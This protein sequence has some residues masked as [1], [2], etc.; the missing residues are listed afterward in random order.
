MFIIKYIT[1]IGVR[2][3]LKW[4]PPA[5]SPFALLH[6][7]VFLSWNGLVLYN[8]LCSVFIGPGYVKKGW[9]PDSEFNS[10]ANRFAG[11]DESDLETDSEEE[12]ASDED[13]QSEEKEK[14]ENVELFTQGRPV[15]SVL[16][17]CEICEGYKAPRAHHCRRCNRC[18]MKMDHHCPWI[19]NCVGHLNHAN[20]TLFLFFAIVGCLHAAIVISVSLYRAFHVQWYMFNEDTY[21]PLVIMGPYEFIFGCLAIGFCIGVVIAV[22]SLLYLQIK[23]IL[24]N[25]T[26]IEDWIMDKANHRHKVLYGKQFTYPYHLGWRRNL[27]AVFGG[28]DL[29][30]KGYAWP[31]RGDCDQFTLTAEQVAQKTA[32]KERIVETRVVAPYS[33]SWCPL[34][35]GLRT[36]WGQPCSDEPRA[37]LIVGDT[38]RISRWKRYAHS[39]AFVLHLQSHWLYGEVVG[40]R[41]KGG[42]RVKGWFPKSCVVEVLHLSDPPVSKPSS[43]SG[44]TVPSKPSSSTAL[45]TLPEEAF[46]ETPSGGPAGDTK[47][48]R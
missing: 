36:C 31:I 9:K 34:S 44:S 29:W 21:H 13:S 27:S 37:P 12:E 23:S 10:E 30:S 2:C 17:Y 28:P 18:V 48:D 24:R 42:Y 33:G 45:P 19:N 25:R 43:E 4:C 26:P 3:L 41:D 47:K 1:L 15:D 7:L 46:D 11:V 20:F 32:K 6:F 38:V 5:E 16:Q 22:G 14:E 35:K 40:R 8:Y 39:T